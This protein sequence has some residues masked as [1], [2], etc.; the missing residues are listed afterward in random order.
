MSEDAVATPVVEPPRAR[1]AAADQLPAPRAARAVL[2]QQLKESTKQIRKQAGVCVTFSEQMIHL[3]DGETRPRMAT[4]YDFLRLASF[5]T[6][7]ARFVA[8]LV[9]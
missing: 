4:I 6:P 2:K 9:S 8:D 1:A 7:A 5:P 3:T